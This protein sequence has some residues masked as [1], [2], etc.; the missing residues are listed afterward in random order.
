MRINVRMI[1]N[2][3]LGLNDSCNLYGIEYLPLAYLRISV[4]VNEYQP[5]LYHDLPGVY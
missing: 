4:S 2:M 5:A 1:N 3:A